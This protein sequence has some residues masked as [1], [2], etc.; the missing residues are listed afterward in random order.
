MAPFTAATGRRTVRTIFEAEVR[1]EL[2]LVIF[3]IVGNSFLPY[4]IRN[5][6]GGLVKVGLGKME[7]REFRDLACSG[8]PGV[9]GPAAPACGLCLVK[10]EYVE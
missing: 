1:R 9:V 5:T 8:R 4:Q 2:D 10:V 7:W 6:V 3:R